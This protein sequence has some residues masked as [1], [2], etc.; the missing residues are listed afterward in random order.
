CNTIRN[1]GQSLTRPAIFFR[2]FGD[3]PNGDFHVNTNDVTGNS[4]GGVIDAGGAF[5]GTVDATG[6][7]WGDPSGPFNAT[8]N[9]G[10]LGDAVSDDVSFAPVLS[11]P[12]LVVSCPAAIVTE[13]TNPAGASVSFASPVASSLCDPSPTTSC[14][15]PSGS[16][17]PVGA[18]TVVC[19]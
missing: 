12:T 4:G 10:G 11:Q 6:N 3:G 2:D 8:N 1:M 5:T 7:W 14:V 16:T 19:T 13:C 15:P 18:T 17:F 9:P